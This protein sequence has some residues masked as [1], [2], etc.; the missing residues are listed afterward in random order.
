MDNILHTY[1]T[2]VCNLIKNNETKDKKV[3]HSTIVPEL[4]IEKYINR[5]S[6]YMH[7]EKEEYY[8]L[9]FS[10]DY[11]YRI[12]DYVTIDTT[13]IYNIIMTCILVAYK[14]ICDENYTNKYCCRI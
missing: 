6:K 4:T 9:T 2:F 1:T 10:M 11:I 12:K 7:I 5:I 14:F 8:V 13:S 3:F